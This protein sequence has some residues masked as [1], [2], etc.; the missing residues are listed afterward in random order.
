MLESLSIRNYA[1]IDE[2]SVDFSG[3]LTVITGETGAGKSII[4]DALELAL[5]A[6]ASAEMIR[7]GADELEI[8]CVFTLDDVIRTEDFPVDGDENVLVLR[9]VV[10]ADGTGKCFIN[11]RQ[12][13]LKALKK[14]GDCLVDLHGQ[15]DH[16]SLLDV[17]G[18]IT[19]LDG[20]GE[21]E[22]LEEEVNRLN[23]E[24]LSAS[25]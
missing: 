16:Q 7:A 13:T 2:M 1:I 12:I 24:F 5:G 23:E 9:R 20:F 19:F 4:V 11:D 22:E 18:H 3:G 15:H 21:F 10:R 25:L 6:R 14:I 8:S 17:A